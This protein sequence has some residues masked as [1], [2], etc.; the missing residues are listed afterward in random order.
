MT[1]DLQKREVAQP[2]IVKVNLHPGPVELS[3]VHCQTFW[4][5]V[6][7]WG[8]MDVAC[9]VDTLPK[10]PSKEIDTHDAED[11]PEDQTYQQYVHDGGDGTN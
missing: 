1:Y 4:F 9:P 11:Q 8:V 10:F 2:Y 7:S 5:I 6:H 3:V